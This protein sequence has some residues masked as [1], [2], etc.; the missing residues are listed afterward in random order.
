[1]ASKV[2]K[3]TTNAR[4]KFLYRQSRY[5]TPAYSGLLI[6]CNALIQPD[7]D[8]G[9]SS[10]FPL[11][12]KNLQLKLQKGQNKCICFCLNLLRDLISIYLILEE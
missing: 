4:Q 1:M 6:L 12:K 9:C 2:K 11:L 8:Y 7:F 3:T 10:C 5:P